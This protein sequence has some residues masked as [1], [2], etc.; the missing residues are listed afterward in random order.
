MERE[1]SYKLRKGKIDMRFRGKRGM[2]RSGQVT[3]FVIIAIVLVA[4][5]VIAF[6]FFPSI[7]ETITG[8]E[9]SPQGFLR[10]C[11]SQDLRTNVDFLGTQGGYADPEGFILYEGNKVKYLC[12]TSEY[13]DTCTVQ[14]PMIK[15]KFERELNSLVE[16]KANDCFESL[17]EEYE[18]R[19]FSISSGKGKSNVKII[20]GA[21][22]FEFETPMTIIKETTRTFDGFSVDLNSEMYDLLLTSQSIIDFESTLGDS[23]T[24]LYITYY[25]DLKIEKNRLGDGSTVY[26]L[27]NVVTDEEFTFAS[28]SLVWPPG[29]GIE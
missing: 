6:V 11:V 19:G 7:G 25:P 1:K 12:Y 9:F 29:Y 27:S 15:S 13:Y 20:P 22:R 26:K 8:T 17:Q 18:S 23:E 3:L 24:S 16:N 2:N 14:S 28:R 5:V 4:A 21:I 10:N